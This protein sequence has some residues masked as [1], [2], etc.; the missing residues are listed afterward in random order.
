MKIQRNHNTLRYT[1]QNMIFAG[2]LG[3]CREA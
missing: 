1:Y 3:F 2:K